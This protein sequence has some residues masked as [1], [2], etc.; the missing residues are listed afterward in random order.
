MNVKLLLVL[1]LFISQLAFSQSEKSIK[2]TVSSE[3][4]LLQNVDVINKTSKQ[5]TKTNENGEFSIAVKVNDSL[6]FYAKEYHW[7]R[8]KVSLEQIAADN[9]NILMF[10]KPEELEEVVITKAQEVKINKNNVYEQGKRDE[11]AVI[12]SVEHIK[13][14]TVYEG[15]IDNPMNFMRIGKMIVDLFRKDKDPNRQSTPEMDFTVLAKS[16]C[17]EQF[18]TKT[19]KLKPEEIDLF[20][21]FCDSDPK[22][23]KLKENTNVLSMMDFLTIKNIEFQKLKQEVK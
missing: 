7:H 12:N 20:L 2:G 3:G 18:F 4:F 6:L 13:K 11:I 9:L 16:T 5:A 19:L 22:S 1:S 21:Q 10:K 15:E 17:N 23:K 14:R 8:L